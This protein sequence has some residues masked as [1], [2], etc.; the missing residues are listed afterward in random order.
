MH[1][2]SKVKAYAIDQILMTG[3]SVKEI[4]QELNIKIPTLYCWL[5]K[6]KANVHESEKIGQANIN[7]IN[8]LK[9][10]PQ[11]D[12]MNGLQI[13]TNKLLHDIEILKA[14]R[15]KYL[16]ILEFLSK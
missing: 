12:E 15:I 7:N 3:K 6:D 13:A 5:K 10:N 2:D 1:Y 8:I 14:K 9:V 11:T 4:S 16:K